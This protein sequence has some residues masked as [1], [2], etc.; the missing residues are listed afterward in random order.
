MS[1]PR[2]ILLLLVFLLETMRREGFELT[3]SRPQV[4]MKSDEATGQR[5]EPIEEVILT[6][7]CR[8]VGELTYGRELIETIDFRKGPYRADVGDFASAGASSALGSSA[9]GSSAGSLEASSAL[10][11]SPPCWASR[12]LMR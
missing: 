9:F 3:V 4:V 5:L 11:S 6:H 12:S 8:E 2:C 1:I 7:T 10:G